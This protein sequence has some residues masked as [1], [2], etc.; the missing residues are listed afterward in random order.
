[1][2]NRLTLAVCCSVLL[3]TA[4]SALALHGQLPLPTRLDAFL[5]NFVK[6]TAVERR[7]LFDGLPVTRSLDADP[8]TEVAIFGA[9]WIGAP[10][11]TYV[12]RLQDIERFEKG[13]GF[14]VTKK[15]GEPARVEDFAA[16]TLPPEDVDDLRSCVVGDCELKL[17]AETLGRVKREIDWKKPD[18][19]AQLERLM[20]H[21]AADYVNAYREGGNSRLA[22]YRDAEHPTFVADEFRELVNTMPL[23][24]DYLPDMRHY[25]L[26]YPKPPTRP[27]ISFFYWQEV[28][29]GLKPLIRISHVGIQESAEATVVASKQLYS[30]HYFWTALELRA[31]I[32]DPSRGTGFWFVNVNRSRL[33]GLSGFVGWLIRGR[34]REGARNGLQSVLTATKKTLEGR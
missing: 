20:R 30:S 23:L 26:E 27:T 6:L 8:S 7:Q 5:T 22:V 19:K 3:C 2:T 28:T 14:R 21:M 33:D 1:M 29:F 15:I 32:P 17:T 10:A 18:V 34:V 12:A 31:L 16:L 9:I 13:G 11:A 4:A 24:G 25:L